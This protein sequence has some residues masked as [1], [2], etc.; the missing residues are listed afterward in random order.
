MPKF[1]W[2]EEKEESNKEKHKI[3]FED[4]RHFQ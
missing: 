3:S 1:E 4:K 2:D